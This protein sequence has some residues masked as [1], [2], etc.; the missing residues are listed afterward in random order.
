MGLLYYYMLYIQWICKDVC[1]CAC[2]DVYSLQSL[3]LI[4][5]YLNVQEMFQK[6]RGE[7]Q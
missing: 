1:V 5:F 3:M 6:A 7:I 2:A 4:Y